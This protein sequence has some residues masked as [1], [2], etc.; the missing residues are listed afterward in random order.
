[1]LHSVLPHSGQFDQFLSNP[2]RDHNMG[3]GHYIDCYD[4]M[5]TSL[6]RSSTHTH[7]NS[8]HVY[9]CELQYEHPMYV[10]VHYINNIHNYNNAM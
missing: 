3:I 10:N 8:E 1:M 2:T 6:G 5:I 4:V 7:H 9:H